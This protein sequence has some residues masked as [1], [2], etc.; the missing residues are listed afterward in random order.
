[1]G[2]EESFNVLFTTINFLFHKENLSKNE[3][4]KKYSSIIQIYFIGAESTAPD[5]D[6]VTELFMKAEDL[7]ENF[8]KIKNK[9]DIVPIYMILF[10]ELDLAEKAQ[11]I[12]LKG[13][14]LKEIEMQLGLNPIVPINL[15]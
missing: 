15:F 13:K 9:D 10:D 12:H 3:N 2:I 7:Y 8:L 11:Q 5:P 1:M 14:D 6:D 4:F